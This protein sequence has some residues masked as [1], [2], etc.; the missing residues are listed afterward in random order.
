MSCSSCSLLE[1]LPRHLLATPTTV[2]EKLA[3]PKTEGVISEISVIGT[4]LRSH[5]MLK[6]AEVAAKKNFESMSSIFSSRIQ[7]KAG[8]ISWLS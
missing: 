5:A 3:I 1:L 7:H 8:K 4:F 2:S 6:L